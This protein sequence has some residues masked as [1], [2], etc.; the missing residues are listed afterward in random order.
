MH[1]LLI[2]SW[3]TAGAIA[4][5]GV[6]AA[7]AAYAARPAAVAP[8]PV[9]PDLHRNLATLTAATPEKVDALQRQRADTTFKL[10]SFQAFEAQIHAWSRIWNIQRRTAEPLGPAELRRCVLTLR[11]PNLDAWPEVV[12]TVKSMCDQPG[13][14]IDRLLLT[15]TSDGA[16]FDRVEIEFTVRLRL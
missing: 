15:L 2:S 14:T 13:L 8:P 12:L 6:A 4:T 3:K 9:D 11:E 5:A 10:G 7:F 16:K 1:R